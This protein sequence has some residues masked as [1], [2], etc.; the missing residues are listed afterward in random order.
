M[1][2]LSSFG[3]VDIY[4]YIEVVYRK[5]KFQYNGHIISSSFDIFL[6]LCCSTLG[7]L[8]RPILLIEF[9]FLNSS[10]SALSDDLLDAWSFW[11]L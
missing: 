1:K 7:L 3:V 5:S 8:L 2:Q 9:L 10:V 4:W 11:T 6:F